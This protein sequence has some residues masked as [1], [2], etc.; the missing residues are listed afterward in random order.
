MNCRM[1]HG[2]GQPLN[3]ADNGT[4]CTSCHR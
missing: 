4:E 1:C 3:H 2:H